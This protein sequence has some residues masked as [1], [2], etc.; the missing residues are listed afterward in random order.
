MIVVDSS[1]WI[2]NLRDTDTKAVRRLRTFHDD[3]QIIVGDI[4]L[5]EVLQGARD[6]LQ[7]IRLERRLRRFDVVTMLDDALAVRAA[8]NY[9]QLRSRGITVR[10]TVD[11]IIGTFCIERDHRLL[12]DDR[13]FD[14]MVEHLGLRLA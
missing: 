12:H 7:A 11:M 8:G 4:I 6:D 1:V 5:L 14:P 10:K 2:A 13:D 3:D 9:R